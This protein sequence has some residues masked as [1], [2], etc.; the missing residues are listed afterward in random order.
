MHGEVPVISVGRSSASWR[1]FAQPSTGPLTRS[2]GFRPLNKGGADVPG[3]SGGGALALVV[4]RPRRE[5]TIG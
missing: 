4:F 2:D 1:S 3:V 5:D